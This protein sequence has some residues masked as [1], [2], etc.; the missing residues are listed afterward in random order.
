MKRILQQSL[1][2]ALLLLGVLYTGDYLLL[3]LRVAK[4]RNPYGVVRVQPYYAV[5]SKDGKSEQYYFL[6]PQDRTCVHSLFPHFGYSPCWR[7][8]EHKQ[9]RIDL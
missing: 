6:D 5:P 2:V 7:L 4:H 1:V 3:R 8:N 9:R